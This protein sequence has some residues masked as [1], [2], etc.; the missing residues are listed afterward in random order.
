MTYCDLSNEG[1]TIHISAINISL[2][3]FLLINQLTLNLR[4]VIV[5]A[6]FNKFSL[7]YIQVIFAVK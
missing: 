3:F 4:I 6:C 2:F 7:F 1:C 5:N